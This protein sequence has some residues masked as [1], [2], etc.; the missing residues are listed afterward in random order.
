MTKQEKFWKDTY[1][2][3]YIARN[4]EFD[5]DSGIKAWAE[6]TKKLEPV[7][8]LLECGCNIGRNINILNHLM[9]GAEKSVIE[10]S[11]EAYSVVTGRYQLADA[12]NCPI[13][14]SDFGGKQFDLVFTSGVLI[15]IAPENLLENLQKIYAHSK[16]YIIC[17]EMF[18]RVP[19]TVHYRGENDLLFT[20]DYGRYI[21]ENFACRVVDYG[22]LWGHYYDAAGFDDANYWVF[23]KTGS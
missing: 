15:H 9:P 12:L 11:P 2:K 7:A 1:A 16:K 17:C 19:K 21:L 14:S 22:F 3:E 10:I 6:M 23:E 13:V 8:S 5:L 4:S 20:R 18:S